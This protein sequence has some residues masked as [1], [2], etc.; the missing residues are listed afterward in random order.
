M[1][2]IIIAPLFFFFGALA[3]W[4]FMCCRMDRDESKYLDA[5]EVLKEKNGI[6]EMHLEVLSG[7]IKKQEDAFVRNRKISK[8]KPQEK[9]KC[10]E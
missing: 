2:N 9:Q 5:I 7:K 4:L 10:P 8:S 3:S 6:L 1:N